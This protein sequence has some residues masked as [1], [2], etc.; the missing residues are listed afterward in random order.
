MLVNVTGREFRRKQRS[1]VEIQPPAGEA[2]DRGAALVRFA[3]LHLAR[4]A[5]KHGA[6]AREQFARLE[7]LGHVVVGADF[8]AHHLIQRGGLSGQHD[9]RHVLLSA[10][11]AR[12]A[13]A[14]IAGRKR[15]IEQHE[16]EFVISQR[17]PHRLAVVRG[18]G[19]V[20]F[21]RKEPGQKT[22]KAPIVV[23]DQYAS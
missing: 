21:A 18:G 4:A 1:P 23:D 13:Y 14:V 5:P 10:Q 17:P 2:D 8:E 7:R 9:E 3:D 20:S 6:D 19:G 11:T 12:Q 15:K 16:H 22:A